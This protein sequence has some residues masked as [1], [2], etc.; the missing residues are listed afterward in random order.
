LQVGRQVVDNGLAGVEA[1]GMGGNVF[2]CP[3]NFVTG[4]FKELVSFLNE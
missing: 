3:F 4:E 2:L 1:N